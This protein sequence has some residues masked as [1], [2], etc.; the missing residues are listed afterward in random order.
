MKHLYDKLSPEYKEKVDIIN[1]DKKT[2]FV[3]EENQV[4]SEV[5]K[6]IKTQHNKMITKQ[7][8]EFNP[9]YKNHYDDKYYPYLPK[10][11]RNQIDSINQM[12][13]IAKKQGPQTTRRRL[14]F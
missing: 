3:S 14:F 2:Y 6:A 8:Y 5:I 11:Q 10:E 9:T 13:S 4:P 7:N 12:I 1:E